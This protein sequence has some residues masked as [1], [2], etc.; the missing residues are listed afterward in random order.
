MIRL[1]AE[2]GRSFDTISERLTMSAYVD[3]YAARVTSADHIAFNNPGT[4]QK[5]G[6]RVCAA[7][8][9]CIVQGPN[10]SDVVAPRSI[11]EVRPALERTVETSLMQLDTQTQQQAQ[12][13][14]QQ[15]IAPTQD[16]PARG[17]RMA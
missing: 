10:A 5:D 13:L 3:A 4:P 15:S 8:L 12:R 11:T 7:T 9:L 16:D 17:P 6:S 2:H 14:A 1:D